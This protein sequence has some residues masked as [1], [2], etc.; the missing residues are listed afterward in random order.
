[1]HFG[2]FFIEA[3]TFLLRLLDLLFSFLNFVTD[4]LQFAL[5]LKGLQG[6]SSLLHD[7]SEPLVSQQSCNHVAPIT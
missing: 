6:T 5:V 3:V 4:S 2:Q 7:L 1:M